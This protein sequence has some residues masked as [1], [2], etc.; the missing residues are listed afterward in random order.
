[1]KPKYTW[2]NEENLDL[3]ELTMNLDALIVLTKIRESPSDCTYTSHWC[4]H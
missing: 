1:M 3:E 4:L 2:T